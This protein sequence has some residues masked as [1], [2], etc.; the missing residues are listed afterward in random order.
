[1][2]RVFVWIAPADCWTTNLA[3]PAPKH[4]MLRVFF[5]KRS[6]RVYMKCHDCDHI[7]GYF[8]PVD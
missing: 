7:V 6:R 3:D 5:A 4:R 1:M 8:E 2:R